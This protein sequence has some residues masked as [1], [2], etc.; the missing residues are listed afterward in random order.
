MSHSGSLKDS[1]IAWI[2][3]HRKRAKV[4]GSAAVRGLCDKKDGGGMQRK[5]EK[6]RKRQGLI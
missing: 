6:G 3:G 5:T 1:D 2:Q 4:E